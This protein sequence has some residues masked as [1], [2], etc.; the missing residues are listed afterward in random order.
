M[1][2]PV[3]GTSRMVESAREERNVPLAGG[4]PGGGRGGTADG[5]RRARR[6]RA[7]RRDGAG[8]AMITSAR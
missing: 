6:G 4:G 5:G 2:A 8:G 7:G 3:R 1:R